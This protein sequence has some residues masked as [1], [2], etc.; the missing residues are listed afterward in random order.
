MIPE[1]IPIYS[2]LKSLIKFIPNFFLRRYFTAS[3]LAGLI[4]CDLV[5]RGESVWLNLGQVATGNVYLQVINLSPFMIELDRA[6]FNMNCG[7]GQIDFFSLKRVDLVPG[8]I[9][10]IILQANITDGSAAAI[11]NSPETPVK[12][13]L[14]G[15]LELNCQV[16]NF[17][18]SVGLSDVRPS[19]INAVARKPLLT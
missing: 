6:H 4:Y 7:G 14:T 18:K 13:W 12:A 17:S 11:A 3:K 16:R 2:L 9:T 15:N 5:P 10:Q 8:A 1:S 19:V